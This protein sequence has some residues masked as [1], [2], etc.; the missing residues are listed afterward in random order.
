M[1][2]V[3]AFAVGAIPFA[4]V[5]GSIQLPGAYYRPLVGVVLLMSGVRLLW[6]RELKSNLQP[7][8]PPIWVGVLCGI[9]I[10][11]LSG[12]TGTGGGIFLSPLLLFL[13]W[14]DTRS[15]SGVA[16]VFILCNSVA[17]LLGNIAI[18]KALPPNLWVY[19]IGAGMGA[20]LGTALGI[21]WRT[22]M[23]LKALGFVLLIAG[24][25]LIGVY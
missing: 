2:R 9:G 6:P 13:G 5:G 21:Q 24:L 23:I 8:D 16:A 3:L 12:L 4:F 15:A 22:P 1:A 7:E 11:F 25:K 18:V 10:G 14:S 19:A 20:L 17:G